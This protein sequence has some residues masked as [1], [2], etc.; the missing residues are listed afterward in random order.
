MK[1]RWGRV[2]LSVLAGLA[3]LLNV[4]IRTN[5]A[6]PITGD[7]ILVLEK[8]VGHEDGHGKNLEL[9]AECSGGTLKNIWGVAERYN[10]MVHDG[11]VKKANVTSDKIEVTIDVLINPD[12]FVY[13]GWATYTVSVSRADIPVRPGTGEKGYLLSHYPSLTTGHAT[14][15]LEGEFAGVYDGP[16]NKAKFSG[17]VVGV[18]LPLTRPPEGFMPPAEHEHPRLLFRKSEVPLLRARLNTALGQALLKKLVERANRPGS[19]EVDDCYVA[20]AMVALLTG[21]KATA[22][23]AVNHSQRILDKSGMA[24]N[25]IFKTLMW[26]SRLAHAALMY[27]LAYDQL[28]PEARKR[29]EN[30]LKL[31]GPKTTYKPWLFCDPHSHMILSHGAPHVMGIYPGGGFA[32]LALYGIKTEEPGKPEL[33]KVPTVPAN[34]PPF[35]KKS[36]FERIKKGA[37]YST[38]QN[39][40]K[41][42]LYEYERSLWKE[43]GGVDVKVLRLFRHSYA[44]MSVNIR[45]AIGEGGFKGS[46]EGHTHMWYPLVHPY[47]AAYRNVMGEPVTARGDVDNFIQRYIATTVFGKRGGSQGFGSGNGH[48][49]LHYV[50]QAFRIT[51]DQHKPVVLWYWLKLLGVNPE[52]VATP[53]AAQKI[54]ELMAKRGGHGT[55]SLGVINTLANFPIDPKTGKLTMQPKNPAGIIPRAYETK[56]HGHYTFRDQWKDGDDVVA[57]ILAQQSGYTGWGLPDTADILIRGFGH[58]WFQKGSSGTR[59]F[60]LMNNVVILPEEVTSEGATGKVTYFKRYGDDGSGTVTIDLDK[61]YVGRKLTELKNKDGSPKIVAATGLPATRSTPADTGIRGLRAFAA[62]YSGKSGAPALFVIVDKITGG[63]KKE[64]VYHL[65]LGKGRARDPKQL[66]I[67]KDGFLIASTE[68]NTSMKATFASPAKVKIEHA[69]ETRDVGSAKAGRIVQARVNAL[70]ASGADPKAGDFFVVATLQKG[71]PP[72]VKVEGTGLAAKVTVGEQTIRFDGE[73]IIF[74]GTGKD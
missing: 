3:V 21:D 50:S 5:A 57:Q 58:A 15:S 14:G 13:G 20:G 41:M 28:A 40:N 1:K 26:G 27:D 54:A 72:E 53:G 10:K 47:A 59:V 36:H 45:R 64:W 55:P 66:T 62:D 12:Q 22:D 11:V 4:G 60:R 9:T 69:S 35:M 48:A 38:R 52:D 37:A 43:T 16:R 18:V 73:K 61:L 33:L 68:D 67:N 30:Y 7:I 34:P 70:F 49:G 46:G 23:A 42:R 8:A 19:G 39:S 32:S 31:Y 6:D 2:S 44:H 29:L 24:G 17:R 56:T 25:E 74:G 65:P 63:R 51:P 71:E